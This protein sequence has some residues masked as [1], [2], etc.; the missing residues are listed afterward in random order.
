MQI[1]VI[2]RTNTARFRILQVKKK[3]I[4]R[5]QYDW[6]RITMNLSEVVSARKKHAVKFRF[7]SIT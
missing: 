1:Y 3:K 4:S 2:L 5:T 7:E 6:L